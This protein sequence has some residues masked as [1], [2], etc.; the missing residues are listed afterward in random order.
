MAAQSNKQKPSDIGAIQNSIHSMFYY[1]MD[2]IEH[3]V[4]FY[5]WHTNL[6]HSTVQEGKVSGALLSITAI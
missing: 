1:F 6:K 4:T 2:I 3:S 5:G